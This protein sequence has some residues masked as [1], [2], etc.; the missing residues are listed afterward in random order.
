MNER[1]VLVL[2]EGRH[3]LGKKTTWGQP[4]TAPELPALPT[5]VHRLAD[6]PSGVSYIMG[7]FDDE[8]RIHGR[9]LPL[10]KDDYATS[11]YFLNAFGAIVRARSDG[12]AALVILIDRDRR[13]ASVT[14][15]PLQ[16]GRDSGVAYTGAPCAVGQAVEAFDAWMIADGR[17][18]KA[19]G[20]DASRTHPAPE[21]LD[22]KEGE[23]RHPKEWAAQVFGSGLG[24]G[25]K[26]ATVA[27]SVDIG[28]LK[29]CCP[30]GFAPFAD[31]VRQ[32]IAPVLAGG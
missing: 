1:K 32:R 26:Y 19:A 15:L 7:K 17:A 21:T 5:L 8:A 30:K 28:L 12:F 16:S 22:G 11:R 6:E 9:G 29:R 24:L 25:E 23:G 10:S 3:E 13:K 27:R 31:E 2:C 14:I 4:A 20:G 18:A